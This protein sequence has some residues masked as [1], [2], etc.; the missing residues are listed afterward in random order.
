M[1]DYYSLL[2]VAR[3]AS[4]EEIKKAYRKKAMQYHPDR[5]KDNP[6]AEDK[7]KE[8]SEAYAVLTDQKKRGQY[9]RFGSEGFHQRFSQEDIFRDID[10]NEVFKSFGFQSGGG[11][12]FSTLDDFFHSRS[13]FGGR[14]TV[15][16]RGSDIEK[17]MAVTFEDAALG[18]QKKI[19]IQR[20][21]S[22]EETSIKIPA[23]INSGKKLRLKGKGYPS[24]HGGKPGDLYLKIVVQP[25][26]IYKR[27]GNHIIV[28]LSI[29]LSEA[30]LGASKE[31]PTLSGPKSIKIPPG[32][33]SQSK[34]RMKGMGIFNSAKKER[35]D[36]LVRITVTL[37]KK[38]TKSQ[39][40]LAEQ[41]K[42]SG[43]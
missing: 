36:Q 41:L 19:T 32:T 22:L 23:G 17:E 13:G 24:L 16:R 2:G 39:M 10:I 38:L 20:N 11:D 42:Q 35:G 34:L 40:D 15:S 26:P 18:A 28:D 30:L 31:V 7:F 5:N 12:P 27:E 43:L 33:Q 8:I 1:K 9:D 6:Q 14:A 37:P 29:K 25:H 3:D 21:G 4:P